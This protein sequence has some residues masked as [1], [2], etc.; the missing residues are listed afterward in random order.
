MKYLRKQE[1]LSMLEM[2]VNEK[3]GMVKALDAEVIDL[4]QDEEALADEI[5]RA[6]NFKEGIL[7]P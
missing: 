4:I 1:K 2:I 3:L 5:E 7:T 6:D